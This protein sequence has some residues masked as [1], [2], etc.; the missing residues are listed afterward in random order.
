MVHEANQRTSRRSPARRFRYALFGLTVEF[1]IELARVQK[2]PAGALADVRIVRVPVT[3]P[4]LAAETGMT[5][6][7]DLPRQLFAWQTVG[8]FVVASESRIEVEPLPGVPDLL[9]ALPLL[10]VVF[11]ALLQRRGLFVLHASAVAVEGRG[12][13][14]LGDKGAGKSTMAAALVAAGHDLLADD[15][16]AIDFS[17]GDPRIVPAFGQLKLWDEAAARL[18]LAAENRGRIHPSLA[19]S[20]YALQRGF[21][22]RP[23][24]LRRLYVLSQ[25]ERSTVTATEPAT[26]VATLL[27]FSYM[28][29][30]GEAGIGPALP[31]HFERSAALAGSGVIHDLTVSPLDRL[32]EAIALVE[33]DL[34]NPPAEA[35]S[36]GEQPELLKEPAQ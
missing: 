1:G 10:G 22:T 4:A 2:A 29:R 16:V 14:L 24:P 27:R 26:A 20:S 19:K 17:S 25:A 32:T 8:R 30:F 9:V 21:A 3:H 6:S 7:L 31:Q 15:V 18:P 13:A 34:R 33:S 36:A 12:V 23:A 11:A 35:R 5:V 28:S